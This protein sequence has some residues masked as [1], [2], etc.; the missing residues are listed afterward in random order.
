MLTWSWLKW[1]IQSWCSI[2]PFFTNV[3]VHERVF[4][5]PERSPRC[6]FLTHDYFFPLPSAVNGFIFQV[7]DREHFSSS[8]EQ[9]GTVPATRAGCSAQPWQTKG[10]VCLLCPQAPHHTQEKGLPLIWAAWEIKGGGL[11]QEQRLISVGDH[12]PVSFDRMNS[13]IKARL[14][15]PCT[16]FFFPSNFCDVSSQGVIIMEHMC[17]NDF[18]IFPCYFYLRIICI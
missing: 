3:A 13:R 14:E 18:R 7:T 16:F 17:S 4:A 11:K 6:L 9:P 5:H 8:T 10:F 1:S 15:A 2:I 12:F